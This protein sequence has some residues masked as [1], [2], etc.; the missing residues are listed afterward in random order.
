MEKKRKIRISVLVVLLVAVL[1]A[2]GYYLWQEMYSRVQEK[3]D[4]ERIQQLVDDGE[5]GRNLALLMEQ[6]ADC[7]GWICIPDT[8]LDYPVMYTPNDSQKYLRRNFDGK[9]SFSGVPFVDARCSLDSDNLVVYGHNLK[10]DTMFSS[11]GGYVQSSYSKKHPK[12]EFETKDGV[13]TYS[14]FAVAQ[15]NEDD[16]WYD[17]VDAPN[18]KVFHENINTITE[19]SIYT[20]DAEPEFGRQLLTLTTC[21]GSDKSGRLIVVSVK[22]N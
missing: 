9:Y 11:L 8:T 18:S 20:T 10:N 19:K 4:F 5:N 22:D 21:Y 16:E 13:S 17:F 3:K 2:S 12:I 6:N 14:V 1:A 7:V 15:I